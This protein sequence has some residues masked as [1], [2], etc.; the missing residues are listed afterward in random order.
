[1]PET[2]GVCCDAFGA[3][4]VLFEMATGVDLFTALSAQHAAVEQDEGAAA[5]ITAVLAT[6]GLTEMLDKIEPEWTTRY[7][8]L[9]AQFA[10][11]IGPHQVRCACSFSL[12]MLQFQLTLRLHAGLSLAK[13]QAAL[14]GHVDSHVKDACLNGGMAYPKYKASITSVHACCADPAR[15]VQAGIGRAGGVPRHA[16]GLPE[17]RAQGGQPR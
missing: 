5:Q 4:S 2:A 16:A 15:G 8:L 7:R 3:A 14:D 12:G 13:M 1:M 6:A 11:L 9:A 10:G 17:L